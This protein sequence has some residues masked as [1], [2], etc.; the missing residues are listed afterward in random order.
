MEVVVI[1]LSLLLSLYY[2]YYS[3]VSVYY[4]ISMPC[5]VLN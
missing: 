2:Y 4:Q 3:Q 5:R 1:L